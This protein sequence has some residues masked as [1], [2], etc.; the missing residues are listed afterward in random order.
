[1]P[2][3]CHNL[4]LTILKLNTMASFDIASEVDVQKLDNTVNV[5]RREIQNRYDFK[6]TETEVVLDKKNLVIDMQTLNPMGMKQIEELLMTRGIKQGIDGRAF[7]FGE[8]EE[9]SGKVY[10]K[11]IKVKAGIDKESAKKIVQIIKQ[12]KLKV[13]AA[14]MDDIVRVS[15]KKIDD[16]QAVISLLRSSD[17]NLPL[18]FINMK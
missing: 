13:Q 4:E 14:I 16:L 17:L 12:S 9:Q 10:K 5:V 11:R 3:A 6:N 15:G 8:E 7:D 18:Q 1:M 2:N